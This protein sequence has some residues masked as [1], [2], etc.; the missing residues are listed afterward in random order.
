[1]KNLKLV[2]CLIDE[3]TKKLFFYGKF[4]NSVNG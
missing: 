2:F 4:N 3:L 1:M